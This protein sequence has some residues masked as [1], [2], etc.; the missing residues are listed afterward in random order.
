M[1][2]IIVVPAIDSEK[3]ADQFPE[4]STK[5]LHAILQREEVAVGIQCDLLDRLVF[6]VA[7]HHL[8]MVAGRSGKIVLLLSKLKGELY[9]MNSDVP[10][11]IVVERYIV[12]ATKHKI[13]DH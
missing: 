12:F 4:A 6:L 1:L 2:L 3:A 10:L 9:L 7:L 13:D 11:H 5:I 8:R